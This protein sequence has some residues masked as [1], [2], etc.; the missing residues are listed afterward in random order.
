[1]IA[2]YINRASN[3]LCE[4]LKKKDCREDSPSYRRKKKLPI[5]S[6][7][8]PLPP[9]PHTHTHAHTFPPTQLRETL[10]AEVR[11]FEQMFTHPHPYVA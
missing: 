11:Y 9:P 8:S 10:N 3:Y 1:M 6:G 2:V 4:P 7:A 5:H